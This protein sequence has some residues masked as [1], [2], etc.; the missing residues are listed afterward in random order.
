MQP[1]PAHAGFSP[2][3]P[4]PMPTGFSGP[5]PPAAVPPAAPTATSAHTIPVGLLA[6]IIKAR[7]KPSTK[8]SGGR[9]EPLTQSELPRALPSREAPSADVL[10]AVEAFYSGAKHARPA[11]RGGRGRRE[12]ERDRRSPS[13]HGGG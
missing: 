9:F 4:A 1:Q 2:M 12:R 13:P 10:Q 6:T 8:P 3:P 7:R 11:A 5:P